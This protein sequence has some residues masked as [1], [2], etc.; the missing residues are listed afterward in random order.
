MPYQAKNYTHIQ[1][2]AF[3]APTFSANFAG[4][5]TYKTKL[6]KT[7][8][9]PEPGG[10]SI[11][12]TNR[13][14]TVAYLADVARK[15]VEKTG[16]DKSTTLKIFTVPEFY[17]RPENNE[18]GA[19]DRS[20]KQ[21]NK[22]SIVGNLRK[23]FQT[24]MYSDWLFVLG[25]IVWTCD[26]E[27][28]EGMNAF[29]A[30][31]SALDKGVR[32][33]CLML[34]GGCEDAPINQL[35]K[36]HLSGIDEISND[37]WYGKSIIFKTQL[38]IRDFFESFASRKKCLMKVDNL[39]LCAEVCLDHI[40][41]LQTAK[42]T[43][44]QIN[45]NMIGENEVVDLQF[46]IACGM[47]IAPISIMTQD[48]GFLLR[49]DG[50]GG[51]APFSQSVWVDYSNM[52]NYKLTNEEGKSIKRDDMMKWTYKD[53]VNSLNNKAKRNRISEGLTYYYPEKLPA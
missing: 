29:S 23:I 53:S 41:D 1:H 39:T 13:I 31:V 34:K 7:I 15:Q 45:A 14:L 40:K 49:N 37:A 47:N 4:N 6:E 42:T 2:I 30:E 16:T 48:K 25:T 52:N 33:T 44:A 10:L 28:L 5:A 32:N 18:Q 46:V 20:Y 8:T 9:L 21:S 11:D 50:H 26:L 51:S 12:A 43:L 24:E 35:D 17:F 36:V 19:L 22:E 38:K 27:E 3:E